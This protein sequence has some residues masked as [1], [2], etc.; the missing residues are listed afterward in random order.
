ML[1]ILLAPPLVKVKMK[2]G[3]ES[4]KKILGF[5]SGFGSSSPPC[6]FNLS[7]RVKRTTPKHL[8]GAGCEERKRT[9]SNTDSA[10]RDTDSAQR[11]ITR[12]KSPC[13]EGHSEGEII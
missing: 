8:P 12:R 10:Q 2:N 7:V 5:R 13:A 9:H 6:P 1:Y 4:L 3:E 11:Q